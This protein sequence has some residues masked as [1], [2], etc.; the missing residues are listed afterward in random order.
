MTIEESGIALLT[1]P[2]SPATAAA[3]L[4]AIHRYLPDPDDRAEVVAMLGLDEEASRD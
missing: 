3:A 4:A 1:A 2:T